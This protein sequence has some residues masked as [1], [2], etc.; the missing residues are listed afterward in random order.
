[1]FIY[2]PDKRLEVWRFLFYMVL[3]AG[4]VT[5]RCLPRI[6]IIIMRN[7]YWSC[8]LNVNSVYNLTATMVEA[9]F[10]AIPYVKSSNY[11]FPCR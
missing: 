8:V 3:H 4:W 10:L 1:V 2:R 11:D 6:I 5:S 7:S 9:V